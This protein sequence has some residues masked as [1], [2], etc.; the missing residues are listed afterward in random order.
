MG[1]E[2]EQRNDVRQWKKCDEE[3][4]EMLMKQEQGA[5]TKTKIG[6][7]FRWEVVS[8]PLLFVAFYAFFAL[9]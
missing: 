3:Q 4:L 5:A 2:E 8:L 1:V 7:K 9:H 6:L